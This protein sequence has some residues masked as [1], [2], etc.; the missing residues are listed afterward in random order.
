M[1]WANIGILVLVA[2]LVTIYF[3]PYRRLKGKIFKK[4]LP[5]I[6]GITA[7]EYRTCSWKKEKV[8]GI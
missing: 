3:M 5:D 2:V 4:L 6:S 1:L 8:F 7:M